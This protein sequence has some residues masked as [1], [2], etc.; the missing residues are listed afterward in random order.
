MLARTLDQPSKPFSHTTDE[1]FSSL[2]GDNHQ[3]SIGDLTAELATNAD[4]LYNMTN[5][6]NAAPEDIRVGHLN[7]CN[8][9]NKT[10]E[11]IAEIKDISSPLTIISD[12]SLIQNI[13]R[14][15]ILGITETHLN[16]TDADRDIHI[17]GL[18]VLRLDRKERKGGGCVLY[19]SQISNH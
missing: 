1:S 8:L 4:D 7:I 18:E 13:C 6:L 15:D 12:I 5:E 9:R 10:D 3:D 19:S 11:L 17:D 16:S 2:F 14:F